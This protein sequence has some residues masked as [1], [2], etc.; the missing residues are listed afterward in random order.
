MSGRDGKGVLL[1]VVD[2]KIRVVFIELILEVTIDNVHSACK[3]IKKRFSELR[4]LTLDNDILFKMHKTLK[5]I[6]GVPIYFC[7]PYHS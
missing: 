4:S 5:N 6:L 2:R 1:V 3:R 7:H